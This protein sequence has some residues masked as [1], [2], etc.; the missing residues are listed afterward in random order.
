MKLLVFAHP[1]EAIAFLK[2]EKCEALNF[3][4]QGIYQFPSGYILI[5]GEGPQNA[6]ETLAGFLGAYHHKIDEIINF[7]VCGLLNSKYSNLLHQMVE[8]RTSYLCLKDHL[9]FKSYTLVH[10]KNDL[11]LLDCI[12]HSD[13]VH[14]T[15]LR[16][17][18]DLLD[19]ELWSLASVAKRFKK[20]IRSIKTVSD[21]IN[22][23]SNDICEVVKENAQQY[24]E[25]H[26]FWF[27]S[28]KS[29][30][31]TEQ[32]SLL[33]CQS[34]F[35]FS[36]S[37]KKLYQK[38]IRSSQ[39]KKIPVSKIEEIQSCLKNKNFE[40]KKRRTAVLI[41]ELEKVIHPFKFKLEQDLA[42]YKDHFNGLKGN[43]TFDKNLEQ[44]KIRLNIELENS[45]DF[46]TLIH[47]L[48]T[49]PQ[50]KWSDFFKGN[51]NV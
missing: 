13:R 38:L 11:P 41:E 28:L 50:K 45:D 27:N 14:N 8:I 20:P 5:T 51:I 15:E 35:H 39:I 36:F 26:Y 34:Y 46:D 40:N 1:L 30:T 47:K 21:I 29:E 24:S 12:T 16:P 4:F 32:S 33:P 6:S 23:S 43:V 49:F 10:G 2:N 9:E 19:R 3:L 17:I 48:S 22:H 18:A 42:I 37:Q 31:H 7:G 25:K 44:E